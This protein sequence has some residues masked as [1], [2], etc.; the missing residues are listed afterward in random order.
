MLTRILAVV[1]GVLC[2]AGSVAAQAPSVAP[3]TL[4]PEARDVWNS[5]VAFAKT[6]A[7]RD[8]KAFA[9]FL[10]EEAIFFGQN[11]TLRG[12]AA[13]A[14]GWRR[15]YDGPQA[16]FSWGP[17]RVEVLDSGGLALS[18][19]PVFDPAG[20]RTGTFMSVWRKE[21]DGMWHIIFDKGC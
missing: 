5:E 17:D 11:S 13:V 21:A 4:S 6:M 8:H 20:K 2:V 7:D 1:F 3:A 14:D 9:S 16:P 19:C 15:F 12:K 18:S 10:S